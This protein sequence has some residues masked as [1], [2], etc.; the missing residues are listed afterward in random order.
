V[1]NFFVTRHGKGEVDDAHVLLKHEVKKEQIELGGR[2]IKN[3]ANVVAYLQVESN[4]YHVASSNVKKHTNKFFHEVKVGDVNRSRPCE[5]ETMHGS[6][7]MHQVWSIF[8]R[9]PVNIVNYIVCV[10]L[11]IDHGPK[12]HCVHHEHVPYWTLTKLKPQN[13]YEVREMMYDSDEEIE[14]GTKGEWIAKNLYPSDNIVVPTN[15]DEPFW[16]MSVDKGPH[17]I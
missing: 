10:S 13:T 1:W 3:V 16:L 4:K 6:R 8:I 5:C 14:A 17:S 12:I 9:H 7:S 11:I 2:K 15:I